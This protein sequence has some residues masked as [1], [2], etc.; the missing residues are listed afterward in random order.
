MTSKSQVIHKELPGNSDS[1]DAS[2]SSESMSTALAY[3]GL[4]VKLSTAKTHLRNDTH[5]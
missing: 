3:A 2:N 1:K 4:A 5:C